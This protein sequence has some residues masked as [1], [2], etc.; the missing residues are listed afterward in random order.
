MAAVSL[1]FIPCLFE[2]GGDA[3]FFLLMAIVTARD[4]IATKDSAGAL[5]T[6]TL[7]DI[8]GALLA[9]WIGHRGPRTLL[10]AFGFALMGGQSAGTAWRFD[11]EP[12][13]ASLALRPRT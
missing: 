3:N 2:H 6:A 12:S 5:V 10:V 9:T 11:L 1:H 7:T 13:P 4:A 8:V